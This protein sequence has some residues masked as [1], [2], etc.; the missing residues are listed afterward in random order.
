MRVVRGSSDHSPPLTR[1]DITVPDP[2]NLARKSQGPVTE[3][4]YIMKI[5]CCVL[6]R[7]CRYVHSRYVDIRYVL[8]WHMSHSSTGLNPFKAVI[9][10]YLSY[11]EG[12]LKILAR[13]LLGVYWQCRTC[14]MKAIKGSWL[15]ESHTQKIRKIAHTGAKLQSFLWGRGPKFF[16]GPPNF[17][18]FLP[19]F[20]LQIALAQK[21]YLHFHF[22]F[23]SQN[24]KIHMSY[25]AKK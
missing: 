12:I 15:L 2:G 16:F 19:I 5:S 1:G 22:R 7:I 21:P 14:T 3:C 23:F 13:F 18:K 24:P 11:F 6:T 8:M 20:H 25:L 4:Q 17:S 10:N 9:C